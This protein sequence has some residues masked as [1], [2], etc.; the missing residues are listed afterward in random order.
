MGK[1]PSQVP[2][3]DRGACVVVDPTS[4]PLNVRA[5]PQGQILSVVSNGQ[6]VRVLEETTDAHG[7]RWAHI[8]D[9]NSQPVGWVFREYLACR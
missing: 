5:V 3:D 1:A 8:A 6:L 4:T 9:A 2:L 7:K